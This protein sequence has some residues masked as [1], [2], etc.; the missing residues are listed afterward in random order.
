MHTWV[1]TVHKESGPL[2]TRAKMVQVAAS[3]LTT[4]LKRVV[5]EAWPEYG[6]RRWSGAGVCEGGK[7]PPG[8][9]VLVIHIRRVA[10]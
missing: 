10:K 6:P 8:G 5:E 1:V 3:N 7:L 2:V 9:V 4:A